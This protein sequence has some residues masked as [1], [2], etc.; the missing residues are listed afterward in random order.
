MSERWL[1]PELPDLVNGEGAC[2]ILGVD[3]R[4]LQRWLEPGTG[5]QGPDGTWMIPPRVVEPPNPRE[6]RWLWVRADVE[7]FAVEYGRRRAAPAE[8]PPPVAA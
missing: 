4:T 7:R 2:R 5:G 1:T 3:R 6:V 8:R